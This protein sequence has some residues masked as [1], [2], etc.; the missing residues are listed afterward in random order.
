MGHS[1]YLFIKNEI[2]IDQK[3]AA[4]FSTYFNTTR[5]LNF[6]IHFFFLITSDKFSYIIVVFHTPHI[7]LYK[8]IETDDV[9]K[10][11][12]DLHAFHVTLFPKWL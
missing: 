2:D 5:V 11:W 6:F 12:D 7:I 8:N 9:V 1:V 4:E 10:A 3:H